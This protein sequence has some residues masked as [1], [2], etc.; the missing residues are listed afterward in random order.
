[1]PDESGGPPRGVREVVKMIFS[2]REIVKKKK[3]VREIVKM[4]SFVI[5]EKTKYHS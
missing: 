3:N 4:M 2:V 1:M 5:R